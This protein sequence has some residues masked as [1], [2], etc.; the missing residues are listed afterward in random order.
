MYPNLEAEMARKEV[1]KRDLAKCLGV[2]YATIIEKTKGK[3]PFLLDEALKIKRTF[4]PQC[5]LEYL[6]E[7]SQSRDTA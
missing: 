5:D 6:F 3:R 4:F 2:R 7:K 1:K